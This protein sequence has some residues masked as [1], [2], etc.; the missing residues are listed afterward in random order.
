MINLSVKIMCKIY[1]ILGPIYRYYPIRF[2]VVTNNLF[3]D[4]D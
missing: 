1:V 2:V 3:L 4:Q